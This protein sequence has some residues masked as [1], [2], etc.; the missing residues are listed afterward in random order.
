VAAGAVGE[1]HTERDARRLALLHRAGVHERAGHVLALREARRAGERR[2]R[3]RRVRGGDE[4]GLAEVVLRLHALHLL[5]RWAVQDADG[6]AEHGVALAAVLDGVVDD[7]VLLRRL[8]APGL[9]H[10]REALLRLVHV[11]LGEA[12]V[13]EDL[14]RVQLELEPELL[15]VAAPSPSAHGRAPR[16]RTHMDSLPRRYRSASSKSLNASSYRA[17]RKLDT[18]HWK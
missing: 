16:A 18:P 7:V 5:L 11:D 3:V 15:V 13:E 9:L 10:V 6:D 2:E 17:S 12:L 1:A 8:L 4:L 14:G